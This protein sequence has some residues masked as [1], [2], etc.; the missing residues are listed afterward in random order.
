MKPAFAFLT[1]VVVVVGLSGC[2]GPCG[3][4]RHGCGLINGT[5]GRCADC[6]E[7]CQSCDTND[8][9]A[10]GQPCDTG[11][12]PACEEGC[13][14]RVGL[15]DRLRARRDVNPGPPTGAV[16]YP[17]YTLR[18]PRDFLASKPASIGP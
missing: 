6:P 11:A 4:S 16:A 17:Y 3:L 18:G 1:V 15:L 13:K 2:K 8:C 5:C 12:A 7:T 10:S 14:D 9:A